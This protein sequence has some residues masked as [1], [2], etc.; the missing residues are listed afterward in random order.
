MKFVKI[1]VVFVVRLMLYAIGPKLVFAYCPRSLP[2]IVSV[3]L[4]SSRSVD[5]VE[6]PRWENVTNRSINSIFVEKKPSDDVTVVV[7]RVLGKKS[8]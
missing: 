6:P 1:I 3:L 4:A 5:R 7:E 2:S 8:N